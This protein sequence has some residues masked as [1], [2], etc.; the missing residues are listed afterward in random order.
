MARKK[1]TAEEL[2]ALNEERNRRRREKR[3]RAAKKPGRPVDREMKARVDIEEWFWS[4]GVPAKVDGR[5]IHTLK[6][7]AEGLGVGYGWLRQRFSRSRR[8]G[9]PRPPL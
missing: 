7:L 6:E 5:I 3:P 2:F 4:L 1:A 8:R 9:K